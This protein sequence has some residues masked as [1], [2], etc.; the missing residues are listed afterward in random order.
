MEIPLKTTKGSVRKVAT[1]K[2]KGKGG[3]CI[4]NYKTTM[5]QRIYGAV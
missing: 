5:L 1:A 3:K 4:P 2:K